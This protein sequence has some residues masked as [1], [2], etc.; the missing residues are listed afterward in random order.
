MTSPEWRDTAIVLY[1]AADLV[2][3]VAARAK[4]GPWIAAHASNGPWLAALVSAPSIERKH[5][6]EVVCEDSDTNPGDLAWMCLLGPDIASTLAMAFRA[7]AG[8]LE[9]SDF[10]WASCNQPLLLLARALTA[11]LQKTDETV[12]VL[13][14]VMGPR[15][16]REQMLTEI[17]RDEGKLCDPANDVHVNPHRGC[18]LR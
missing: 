8:Y 6:W 17:A 14:A 15:L 18:I 2:E 4:S 10:D 1:D 7:E 16:S 13:E 9:R 3:Q 5:T 12:P 11:G